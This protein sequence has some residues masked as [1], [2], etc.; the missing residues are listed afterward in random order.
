MLI[1]ERSNLS[2]NCQRPVQ[3]KLC[4]EFLKQKNSVSPSAIL[5]HLKI[6]NFSM[7][8]DISAILIWSEDYQKLADWYKD[9]LELNV[10][11]ELNHPDDTG[12][13]F[14][15]GNMLLWIGQHSQ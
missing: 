6:T 7:I 9:K 5:Q 14:K 10:S 2:I 1:P 3:A 11:H 13:A 12:V 15:V 4:E 8:K